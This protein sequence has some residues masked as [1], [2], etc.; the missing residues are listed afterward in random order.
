[1]LMY[2][3]AILQLS[4]IGATEFPQA[5]PAHIYSVEPEEKGH[6]PTIRESGRDRMLVCLVEFS[7][8]Q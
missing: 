3:R 1:M 2:V 4:M 7:M 5:E 8:Y 6:V